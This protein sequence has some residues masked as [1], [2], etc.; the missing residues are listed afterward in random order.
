M[1]GEREGGRGR[2][3]EGRRGKNRERGGIGNGYPLSVDNSHMELIWKSI[4]TKNNWLPLCSPYLSQIHITSP[5]PKR[6][7]MCG[8]CNAHVFK[9][10]SQSRWKLTVPFLCS[11][12]RESEVNRDTGGHVVGNAAGF[13]GC[14]SLRVYT[15]KRPWKNRILKYR[16]WCREQSSGVLKNHG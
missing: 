9:G 10:I 8:S 12:T 3:E 13:L 6:Q 4:I 2:E 14:K 15:G 5:Y 1:E 7:D 11:L 16:T